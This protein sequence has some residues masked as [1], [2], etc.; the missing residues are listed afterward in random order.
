MRDF[1]L[2]PRSRWYC[3]LMGYYAARSGNFLP[4][5]PDNLLVRNYHYSLRNSPEERSFC[6]VILL[7]LCV[8]FSDVRVAK[9]EPDTSRL[10]GSKS[11][12]CRSGT[13]IVW[14]Q[15]FYKSCLLLAHIYNYNRK[16]WLRVRLCPAYHRPACTRLFQP[17]T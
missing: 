1:R 8:T 7:A 17:L 4:T 9:F 13:P 11:S 12:T 5:F 16:T 2:P 15:F 3:A 10:A 14:L 6:S